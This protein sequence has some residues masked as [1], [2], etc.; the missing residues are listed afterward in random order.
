MKKYILFDN[1]GVLVETEKW[2][3]EAN[4]KA[5]K[6]LGLN[7]EM[8]FYQ[9][10][11]VKGGSAFELALLHNIEH[12]IIEKHRS[13]R[14]SFY[15]EF[16]TTKDIS[17]QNVKDTLKELSKRYKMAIVTTSR[18]VDFELIHKNS[19]ITNFMDFILCVE[20]YK[21]AKPHPDPY[22]KGLEKF[23]SKDFEAIVVE[24]SQ[25]GLESSKR[26]NIDCIVVKNEFTQK[27][28]FSKADYFI[29]NIEEL[30]KL[31]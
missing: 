12:D 6:L 13:I 5:L 22:L 27:Q 7:L 4:K 16:I 15:Q 11:M 24:D 21:R 9:N 17:I 10:I 20:D 28:D 31:L 2:Y 30:K 3:F 23:N 14:D 18:R 25:R 19:G 8:E 29:N 1:D 26:A